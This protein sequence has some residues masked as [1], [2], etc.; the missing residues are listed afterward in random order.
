MPRLAAVL[1]LLLL[2]TSAGAAVYRWVDEAGNVHFGDCPPPGCASEEIRPEPGV[3]VP[4]MPVPPKAEEAP[5]AAHPAPVP[6]AAPVRAEREPPACND[7]PGEF[8]GEAFSDWYRPPEPRALTNEEQADL[9][10]LLNGLEGW[11]KGLMEAGACEGTRAEPVMETKRY[12]VRL[13]VE[14]DRLGVWRFEVELDGLDDRTRSDE[15]FWLYREEERLT[16][17][18]LPTINPAG[19]QWDIEVL[20]VDANTLSFVR[21]FHVRRADQR[22]VVRNLEYRELKHAGGRLYLRQFTFTQGVL[23]EQRVWSLERWNR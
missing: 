13:D 17:G 22:G 15:L 2:G 14:R 12:R 21:F 23:S 6:P 4:A 10:R 19:D 11:W 7:S 9:D 1:L 3:I 18:D 16:W 8:L 5:P 20:E